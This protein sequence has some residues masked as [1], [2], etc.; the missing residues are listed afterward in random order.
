MESKPVDEILSKSAPESSQAD[1]RKW[2][3]RIV[4]AV[5]LGEAVRGCL[6][7]ITNNLALPAMARV[8]GGDPQSPLYLGKG[9]VN[10]QALFISVLELCFAGIVAVLLNSWSQKPRLVRPRTVRL[11]PVQASPAPVVA[12]AEPSK[13][14]LL[15]V[16]THRHL[17]HRAGDSQF[18]HLSNVLVIGWDLESVRRYYNFDW[19]NGLAQINLGDRTIDVIPTPGHNATHVVFYDRNTALLFSGDFL[20]PGRLLIDDA[21]ADLASARRVA[22]FVKD[23]PVS[24]V[25]GGHIELDSTG[26][27]FPW[28]SQYHPHEHALQMSKDDLLALPSAV[29]NFN[30]FYTESGRFILINSIH[31]FIALAVI[32]GVVLVAF[33]L[34]LILYIR[35]RRASPSAAGCPDDGV[36]LTGENRRGCR[37]TLGLDGSLCGRGGY[38][39]VLLVSRR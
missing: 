13:L 31:I 29:S 39:R 24:Y 32:A 17:D 8:M 14:P 22:A 36:P 3:S 1:S 9:D 10:V 38:C 37:K 12:R 2:I 6:V 28:E 4:I 15:V 18:A 26:E 20:M 21:D 7:S 5:V 25:L 34:G 11:T 16:H 35:R 23:R 30:G 33:I 19:P 27:T